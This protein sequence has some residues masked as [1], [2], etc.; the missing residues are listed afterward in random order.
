MSDAFLHSLLLAAA[1]MLVIEGVVP[2]L[3]PAT[4]RRVLIQMAAMPDKH[5]QMIGL[6]SMVLGLAI[7]YWVN[8]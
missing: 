2:F 5:L 8:N 7:L 4:F 3:K 6:F 1:L